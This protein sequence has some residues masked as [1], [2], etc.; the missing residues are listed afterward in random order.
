MKRLNR[1][2]VF[3]FAIGLSILFSANIYGQKTKLRQMEKLSRG[4]VAV[5]EGGGKVF[6]SWR[7]FGTD[8]DK[9]AFNLYRETDGKTLKL[10]DKP[11]ADVTFFID[12]KADLKKTNSYFVRAVSGKKETSAKFTLAANSETKQYLSVPLQTPNGYTANDASVGDL[13]GDGEYE[14]VLHQAG[15]GRDNSQFGMTDAPILQAYK[16]DGTLLWTINLGKNIREGAHY[17]QFMV[18]DFDGDGKA[19]IACKTADGTVDGKGKIIGDEKADWRAP[20]GTF[21]EVDNPD[22][23]GRRQNITGKILSGSEYLTVFDGQTGAEI[24]T[25]DFIPPRHPTKQNPTGN[26]LN[27]IWGD[28]YGNRADRFLAAV[29]Y[30]DGEHPSL[31][32][33]RGY[34]TRTVIAAWDFRDKKLVKRWVFD[35]D[36][37]DENRKFRGQGNHNLSV[38]DV[39]GD[40]KDEIV[41]GAM[42]ID[43]NGKGLYSTGLG[44][45]DAL[46][47]SDLDPDRPGLEVFDIQERFDD[48]GA[49]FRDARTGEILWKKPSIKAGADGEGPGRG[50]SLNIDPR[51]KGFESWVFGARVTGLFSAK[52]EKISDKN[53]RSCN[54]GVFW[55]GDL[56]SELL[57]RNTISKWNWEKEIT[58][59]IFTADG[60]MSNNGTKATPTLSADLFGDWREEVVWRSADN[61]ELRIYTTTIPTKYRFYTFMHD[62]QYRLSIAWQNVAYNQPP[63]TSFYIG[64]GMKQPP[65][66]PITTVIRKK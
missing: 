37:S 17:T 6:V 59:P 31:I 38:G 57:D 36:S 23:G 48:A 16:L 39:D 24:F 53:P 33:S 21:V 65:K 34:Y 58:E 8:S 4:V 61:K 11:I 46:H 18:Y 43:D 35:S 7:M 45:G 40:G 29:A 50:L 22:G 25:T 41:F 47:L 66:P 20:E 15:R 44:H 10:N 14:I 2:T 42:V 49:S 51:Y 5:N 3:I 12:E 32:M 60:A 27:A 26:E 56:L 9:I 19:E 64:E 62:P 55:D 63:H 1:Q 30:L 54:F 28:G 52:G 13:D